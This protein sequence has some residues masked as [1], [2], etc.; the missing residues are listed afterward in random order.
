MVDVVRYQDPVVAKLGNAVTALA[1]AKTIQDTKQVLDI[2]AAAEVYARRQQ[3]GQEAIDYAHS[4]K[5]EAL[6]KLGGM[7]KETPR[8]TGGEYGGR[9]KIDGSERELSIPQTQTLA[10]M[11]LDKKT[12]SLAQK[13]ASLP[14]QTFDL[15]KTGALAVTQAI[16]ETERQNRIQQSVD[17]I[18][19]LE[20]PEGSYRCIVID[21]PWPMA[22]IEREERPNQGAMLDYPVMSLED[23]ARLPV[24]DLAADGC[25]V[26]LWVTQK[27]LPAGLELFN[28]WGVKYQCLMTWVKPT[29]MTPYS[30]MYNTEHV[31]FGRIGSLQLERMGLKLAFNAPTSGHSVK[32]Q[33]FYDLVSQASP[34]PRIDMF[35]RKERE[36][37]TVWG[38]DV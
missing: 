29:G 31:L 21:P 5:I 1:E 12:S 16:N 10:D 15:V 24:A 13:I 35:A 30:W 18:A 3:L 7:L 20:T 6:A 19:T 37:Y 32:P 25:H 36:G 11:G 4:I 17:R 26:Y 23:I 34:E 8:A 2:A 14:P 27:Y 38:S 28:G 9:Q 33:E 22:K